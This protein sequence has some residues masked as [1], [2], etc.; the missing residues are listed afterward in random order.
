MIRALV[1]AMLLTA[2]AAWAGSVQGNRIMV[3]FSYDPSPTELRAAKR[4]GK[5]YFTKAEAAGRPV[6]VNVARSR[7]TILMSLESV[8]I[9]TRAEACPLLVFRD[10]TDRPILE[11]R[12]FQNVLIEYRGPEIYL[13]IRLWEKISECRITTNARSRCNEV[14]KSENE[15]IPKDDD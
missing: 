7:G 5:D 8:A 13:V 2:S 4:W 11:T 1:L 3:E 6:R 10:V 9:C 12:A 15:I 14:K